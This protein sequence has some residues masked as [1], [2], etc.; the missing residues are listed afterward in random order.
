MRTV[1]QYLRELNTR[2]L[3]DAFLSKE[4]IDY[5]NSNWK[6]NLTIRQV[7]KIERMRIC[8]YINRLRSM[9]VT[10]PENGHRWV[11]YSYTV[12]GDFLRKSVETRLLDF[13]E[14]LENGIERTPV[15]WDYELKPQSEIVGYFVADTPINKEH[16]YDVMAEILS[17]ASFFGY[18]QEGLEKNKRM[19]EKALKE[20]E[21][22]IQ[23]E[24]MNIEE[25]QFDN[26]RINCLEVEKES[27]SKEERLEREVFQA[28]HTFNDNSR[29][30]ALSE[31]I[32]LHQE[33]ILS[34][35]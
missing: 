11:L 18:E 34:S 10:K 6:R 24:D 22:Y 21:E 4:P 28:I 13:D 15:S 16:I 33:Q 19:M 8:R 1:Q 14:L 12:I 17:E 9:A 20:A 23:A 27:I 5:D 32:S 31:L 29:E 35:V 3:V 2:K 7:R 30:K 25:V 26:V